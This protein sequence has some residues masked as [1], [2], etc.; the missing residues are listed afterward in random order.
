MSHLFNVTKIF[1][2][3]GKN[4]KIMW[5]YE[6]F[7]VLKHFFSSHR[8]KT[9]IE[10]LRVSS[11]QLSDNEKLQLR[12]CC[13]YLISPTTMKTGDILYPTTLDVIQ[14]G[15]SAVPPLEWVTHWYQR[16]ANYCR[17]NKPEMPASLWK[18]TCESTHHKR[19]LILKPCMHSDSVAT[20]WNRC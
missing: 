13:A 9:W 11:K 18:G 20:D 5:K 7:K 4:I 17:N 16:G 15:Q 8:W 19:L 3:C 2:C 10:S 1:C 6:R 14:V 12:A